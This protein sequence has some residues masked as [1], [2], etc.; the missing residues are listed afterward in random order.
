[1]GDLAARLA[2][3]RARMRAA[4]L[5]AGR[6]P[7]AVELIAVT[8]GFGLEH[9]RAAMALGLVEFGENRIQEALPKIEA[10]GPGPRWHLV[11]HLQRNK[12]RRAVDAF[13]L[14][15]SVD[16]LRLADE[17]ARR[18]R[19]VGRE[20]PILLQVNVAGEPQKHGFPPEQVAAAGRHIA[21]RP[22]VRVRGL[23][24][25][26]PLAADAEA[27]RPVFRRLCQLGAALREDIPDA[28]QLSMGMTDDFEVAI[29]EGATLVRLGR[30]IFGERPPALGNRRKVRE[31]T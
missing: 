22:G 2:T 8:K 28:D 25:I 16:S 18:A 4:A 19:E 20:I 12:V 7:N 17:V 1:V 30:A 27:V 26:A 11:G 29:E 5:R 23:M 6:L 10:I 3:V 15:H 13:V 21:R 31:S 24:T 14:I 9:I